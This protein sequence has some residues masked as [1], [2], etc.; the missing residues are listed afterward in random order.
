M[1]LS[2][3]TS[4]GDFSARSRSIII[5][6]AASFLRDLDA[7]EK[8]RRGRVALQGIEDGFELQLRTL[9][10]AGHLW[11]GIWMT[12]RDNPEPLQ[13]SGGFPID[14]DHS[15]ALFAGLRQLLTP[16]MAAR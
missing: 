8:T 4:I 14:S 7:F 11:V 2:A 12:R 1:V 6:D 5:E 16:T 3:E 15:A 10:S 13:F 9:N